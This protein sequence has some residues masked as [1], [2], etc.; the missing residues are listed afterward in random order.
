[1]ATLTA[2]TILKNSTKKHGLK[3][4]YLEGNKTGDGTIKDLEALICYARHI[5]YNEGFKDG[6][7]VKSEIKKD[8]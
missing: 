6:M 1:M 3:F 5:G 2:K 8:F 4:L 7:K